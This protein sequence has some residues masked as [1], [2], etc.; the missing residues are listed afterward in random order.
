MVESVNKVCKGILKPILLFPGEWV[1]ICFALFLPELYGADFSRGFEYFW[2][3]LTNYIMIYALL[4]YILMLVPYLVSKIS[5]PSARILSG[6]FE[7]A[8][9]FLSVSDFFLWD[10]FGTH[11]N[12]YILQLLAETNS[13]ESSEFISTY[14][15]SPSTVKC[16]GIVGLFVI[17]HFG[18]TLMF[19]RLRWPI[20]LVAYLCAGAVCAV[21]KR[22]GYT[23]NVIDND[24]FASRHPDTARAFSYKIYNAVLQFVQDKKDFDHCADALENVEASIT[25]DS[26]S[27]I[28]LIIG[29][30]HNKYHSSLY[31]YPLCTNPLLERLPNLYVF[32]DVITSVN[33]TSQ[34]FKNF[35]SVASNDE[36]SK[37]C[38]KPLFPCVF[39]NAGYNVICY[40]NQFVHD[41]QMSLYDASC[42]FFNHPRIRDKLFSYKNIYKYQYD[43]ELIA[44]FKGKRD[45]LERRDHNLV[46]FHLNGQHVKASER[47]PAEYGFF[48]ASDYEHRTDLNREQKEYVASYDNATR[49]NDAIICEIIEMYRG[50]DAVVI[51][52]SD[53]GDEVHDFRNHVGRSYN[54]DDGGQ[55]AIHHQMDI[56]FFIY[57]S[58][59]CNARHPEITERIRKSIH[60]P[61]MTDD[62]P[63]LLFDLA[64][65]SYEGYFPSKS[66][67]NDLF[68]IHRSRVPRA[69]TPTVKVDYDNL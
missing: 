31:G 59:V 55:K 68:D 29:E 63:H 6:L 1:V 28:V 18:F 65:I 56:P 60:R 49:Y 30:S 16:V 8:A 51:Y 38:G 5:L 44:D 10:A 17:V 2:K 13:S 4:A 40:S 26:V 45:S 53:H 37:W 21:S 64:G 39:L 58:D 36:D 14:I 23:R 35:L 32:D 7:V 34:S 27:N 33:A 52:F 54:F 50:V 62:L 67:I 20:I 47:Y 11:I 41:P 66:L 57:C 3:G 9:V 15:L 43:H 12:S 25:V 19:R 46:I 69:I 42:G 22:E 48:T 61:Y 24:V